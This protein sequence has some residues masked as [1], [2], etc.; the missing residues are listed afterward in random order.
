MSE[1]TAEFELGKLGGID[2]SELQA[3][4]MRPES[5]RLSDVGTLSCLFVGLKKNLHENR[6]G[7]PARNYSESGMTGDQLCRSADFKI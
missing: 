1:T 7:N 4:V 6:P 5:R 3:A 2:S